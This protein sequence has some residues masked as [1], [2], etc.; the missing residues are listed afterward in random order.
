MEEQTMQVALNE[1]FA[2]TNEE[3]ADAM[4]INYNTIASWR[5]NFRHNA[6]S[7]EK[8]IEILTRMNYTLITESKWKKHQS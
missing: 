7:Q 4:G 5:F 6:M 3:L 8:K 2:K 1:V